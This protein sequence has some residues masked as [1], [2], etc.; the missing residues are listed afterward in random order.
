M[1]TTQ[2]AIAA[3]LA[4][5]S[6]LVAIVNPRLKSASPAR[7]RL[8]RPGVIEVRSERRTDTI[9]MSDEVIEFSKAGATFRGRVGAFI[10]E[11]AHSLVVI[12]DGQV[13]VPPAS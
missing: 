11:A 8:V 4:A 13:Q 10:G 7:C 1:T 2:T 6:G 5:G 3:P 12:D 9:C